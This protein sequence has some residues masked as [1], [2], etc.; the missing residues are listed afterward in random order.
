MRRYGLIGYP[1]GHSF[2]QRYF[3]DKFQR[4]GI[5]DA[6]FDLFPIEHAAAVQTIFQS[7][8][9]LRGLAVTIPHKIT[10]IPFLDGLEESA[11]AIGAVNGIRKINDR[12]IGFNSDCIGFEKTL[13]PHLNS[14]HDRALILGTGGSSKAVAY[15][16]KKLGI[17][18]QFVSRNPSPT[19][20][21]YAELD[22]TC[23]QQHRLI[24]QCTPIGMYPHSEETPLHQFDGIG[25]Q[26][27][28]YDLI[29]NPQETNF[30]QSGK[31]KGATTVNGLGML[32]SQA[33]ENWKKWNES[34]L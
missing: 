20:L 31:Q 3:T 32:H 22:S 14:W 25:A 7:I 24:V 17:S 10:V 19:A 34:A 1:L 30:L 28:L 15:V 9:D 18:H 23:L 26:H 4:E 6:R 16:L 33:E 5:E 2:S 13:L 21:S 27:L 29:Y 8:S 12:W 11:Q